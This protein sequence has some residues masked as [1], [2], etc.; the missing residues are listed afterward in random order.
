M[1]FITGTD[2]GSGKTVLTRLL[3]AFL[4]SQGTH[5]LA[6]KPVCT[7]S[8]EDVYGLQRHQRG[9]LEDDEV[10]PFHYSLPAAPI[11]AANRARQKPGIQA[12]DR[13]VREVRK[14]CD[15]LLVEGA[16]GLLVPLNEKETWL[17]GVMQ[18]ECQVLVAARNQ[19]GVINHATLTMDRLNGAGVQKK[20]VILMNRKDAGAQSQVE[21]QNASILNKTVKNARIFELPYLGRVGVKSIEKAV[22]QKK[23]KK[24]L[25][26]IL[27][28][29]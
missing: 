9:W 1:I 25:A 29:R 22:D 20:C 6:M 27:S 21:Q 5:A 16:G 10:N 23:I 14:Q 2:T 26:E 3:L 4:R 15:V 8:R 19:L 13:A 18:W 17:N 11:L 24:V 12:I 7:G 28:L